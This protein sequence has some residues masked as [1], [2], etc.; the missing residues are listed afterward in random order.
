VHENAHLPITP[1]ELAGV[2]VRAPQV[3]FQRT[4]GMPPLAH[5]RTI[6]LDRVHDELRRTPAGTTS[7]A[8]IARRWGFAHHGR[9]SARN[10]ERLGEQPS[11][12]LRR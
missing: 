1:T 6:R 12:I 5:L 8:E 7:V 2:S 9:F 3:A 10:A 11:D 4:L